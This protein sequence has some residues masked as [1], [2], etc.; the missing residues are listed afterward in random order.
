MSHRRSPADINLKTKSIFK[1]RLELLSHCDRHSG[2]SLSIQRGE[3]MMMMMMMMRIQK[4]VK[5]DHNSNTRT[6]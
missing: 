4:P 5:F 2:Q 6:S 1:S 3:M